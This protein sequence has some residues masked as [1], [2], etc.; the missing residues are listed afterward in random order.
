MSYALKAATSRAALK[1]A[2][3]YLKSLSLE[4]PV[5]DARLIVQHALGTGWEG[6]FLGP[7]RVLNEEERAQLAASLAR[8]ASRE[9]VARIVG[10]R[11]F[12]TLDLNV[13]PSTLDP[14]ADTESLI[15]AVVAA[16]PDR[17]APVRILDLGTGTG[18]L[19]LALLSE[20][21][22]ARGIGV[23]SSAGAVLTAQMN[24]EA[25]G[26]SGRA[27]IRQGDWAEGLTGPFDVIIS[28]PPYIPSGEIAHLSPEVR[29]YDPPEALDGG[30]DGLDAYRR[31]LPAVSAL[32]APAGLAVLEVG[33]GQM[34]DVSA[35][36]A[37]NGLAERARRRDLAGI[38]RALV[39]EPSGA[40]KID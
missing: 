21:G 39:L 19:L 23:D 38:E 26:L 25:H 7:D 14:R 10:R 24:A 16:I 30:P 35:L 8:R 40:D 37:E 6:L 22:N 1:E 29:G 11:H 2:V 9:P 31:I 28:N 20:Y 27:T 34:D 36:A 5:L 18:A 12:W 15:E 33:A 32:L 13:S 17:T 3:V 4:T